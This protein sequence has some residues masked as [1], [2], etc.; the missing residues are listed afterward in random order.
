[1]EGVRPVSL[2]EVLTDI[3]SERARETER[4]GVQTHPFSSASA[5]VHTA[6]A[7]QWK[8]H[9]ERV[10]QDP[11]A[12]VTWHSIAAEELHEAFAETNLLKIRTEAVQTAAVLVA[13]IEQID[14]QMEEGSL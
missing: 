9:N 8:A 11:N 5:A 6:L 14:R 4:W 10:S 7:D 2:N 1:M 12:S 13:M 3:A